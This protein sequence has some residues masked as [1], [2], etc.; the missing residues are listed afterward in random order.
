MCWSCTCRAAGDSGA[1]AHDYIDL[2]KSDAAGLYDRGVKI[3]TGQEV[4][5]AC[6]VGEAVERVGP[7]PVCWEENGTL[8]VILR[9]SC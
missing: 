8:G 9:N 2:D 3:C 1:H 5:G 6:G 7:H 4:L